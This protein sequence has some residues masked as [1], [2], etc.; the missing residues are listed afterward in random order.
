MS[1]HSQLEVKNLHV[2]F[3]KK[4]TFTTILNGVDFSVEK[5]ETLCIVGESGCGKS[6]TSLSVMGLLPKTGKVT[7]GQILFDG[8]DLTEKSQKQM[9]K[10]RGNDISMIFQEPM[11]SLN[12]VH[13]V[14]KQI[15]EVVQLHEKISKKKAME[16]AVD[17]L[18]LVGIPSPEQRVYSYPHELSGGMRQRVMIAMALACNPKL[19]I[20]DEPTTA[21]DV[22]IQA[23][24]LDLMNSLKNDFDMSIVMI[25]HDLGVVSEV[26]DK[27]LV[28]YAGK[29]VEYSDVKSLFNNPQHPYT[30]G[31][32]E[33]IPKLTE[34]TE[35][36]PIIP[37]S[38]PNP[39]N[40][41]RGCRF[42]TRC[43]HAQPTCFN[44]VPP[45]IET[46][47]NHKAS[48]WMFDQRWEEIK[49]EGEAYA[50]RK[51]TAATTEPVRN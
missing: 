49:K 51:E 27:V 22:T 5:G 47:S 2:G 15:A 8:E 16:K 41:P 26:A 35:E 33:S 23:Q 44:E 45:L 48:C 34:E 46:E 6:L 11:T 10:I 42:A 7:E 18:K 9:S 31:L 28:M 37:G 24:I 50:S 25:T 12:P 14:G 39:D 20:A 13:T 17:M 38:V 3:Q 43:P 4:K 1:E 30:K 29:V 36:L 32:I 21:L 40:M 19:L